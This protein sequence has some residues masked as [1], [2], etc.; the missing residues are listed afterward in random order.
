MNLL[1]K[2][3]IKI[4]FDLDNTIYR[5]SDYLYWLIVEFATLHRLNVPQ[6]I[7]PSYIENNLNRRK[8][9]LL[10]NLF[11][12]AFQRYP[13]PEEHNEIFSLYY[14]LNCNI[15]PYD[16]IKELLFFLKDKTCLM[17]ISN[18]VQCVQENKIKLLRI[19]EFF[20]DILILEDKKNQ[21]PSI[22][23]I[24]SYMN[25]S[26]EIIVI[27]DD[28]RTDI[29]FGKNLGA[30]TIRLKKGFFKLENSTADYEVNEPT[31]IIDILSRRYCNE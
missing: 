25:F 6:F 24:K 3:R 9:D 28:P 1:K 21:K 8:I 27:G 18:G 16:G 11:Y 26:K 15:S 12:L 4:I 14:N 2:K 7:N 19:R 10:T 17:L 31:E 5:E 20:D 29:L 30:M 13:S 22:Q 23:N